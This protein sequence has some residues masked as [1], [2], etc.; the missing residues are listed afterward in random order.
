MKVLVEHGQVSVNAKDHLGSTPLVNAA[1]E[2]HYDIVQWLL[3]QG[4]DPT[5]QRDSRLNVL[6]AAAMAGIPDI[7]KLLLNDRQSMEGGVCLSSAILQHVAVSG[8]VEMVKF[9]LQRGGR[10]IDDAKNGTWKGNRLSSEQRDAIENS[11]WL[12]TGKCALESLHVLLDYLTRRNEI[13]NF[14]YFELK[15]PD[16]KIAI[17]DATEDAIEQDYEEVFELMWD[18][19]FSPPTS[20]LETKPEEKARQQQWLHRRI[21]LAS[22]AGAIKTTKLLLEKYGADVNHVSMKYHM[23]PLFLSAAQGHLKSP[24]TCSNL[25]ML[26]SALVAVASKRPDC[27]THLYPEWSIQGCE[28]VARARWTS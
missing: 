5:F 8:K 27:I 12:A 23:T 10:P 15:D 4:A 17:F 22:G 1:R 28:I 21:V 3:E 20:V 7:L 26:L 14:Q 11:L 18:V 9:I 13:G 2:G 24:D 16:K 6:E 25:N 19:I